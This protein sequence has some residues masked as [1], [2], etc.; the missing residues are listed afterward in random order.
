MR[1]IP[2]RRR[3]PDQI[4]AAV[5]EALGQ[6]VQYNHLQY[7]AGALSGTIDVADVA[8]FERALRAAYTTLHELIGDDVERVVFYLAGS[9]PTAQPVSAGALGLPTP[10]SGHDLAQ[11]FG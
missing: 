8:A 6:P 9:T 7:K 11:R 4:A 10:P 5:S 3:D 2:R 1:L